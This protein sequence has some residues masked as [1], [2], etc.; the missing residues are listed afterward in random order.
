VF[1]FSITDALLLRKAIT[2]SLCITMM[3]TA[4]YMSR[5]EI[6][7]T[8]KLGEIHIGTMN[9]KTPKVWVGVQSVDYVAT[10]VGK[11]YP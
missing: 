2:P 4:V 10:H 6:L 3:H 1:I 7:K 9:H 5:V 8:K 11:K